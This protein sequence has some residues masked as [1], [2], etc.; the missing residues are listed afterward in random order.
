M[1]RSNVRLQLYNAKIIEE[2][3]LGQRPEYKIKDKK[4]HH[5]LT[6]KLAY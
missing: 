1:R 3:P 2:M 6:P 4:I 5:E